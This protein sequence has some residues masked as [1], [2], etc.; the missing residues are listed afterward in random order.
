MLRVG[1]HRA[2][3]QAEPHQKEAVNIRK[4]G[5]GIAYVDKPGTFYLTIETLGH[6]VVKTVLVDEISE[7]S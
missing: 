2:E 1:I 4:S 6:W 7:F 5:Q 3:G